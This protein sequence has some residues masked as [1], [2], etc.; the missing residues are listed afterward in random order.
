M[1]FCVLEAL[2]NA[3]KYPRA[4]EVVMRLRDDEG[5]VQLP[6]LRHPCGCRRSGSCARPQPAADRGLDA[7]VG[8]STAQL[9][10]GIGQLTASLR[11]RGARLA[12]RRG[13]TTAA[14]SLVRPSGRVLFADGFWERLPTKYATKMFGDAV[15]T[16][17]EHVE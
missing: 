9:A 12:R 10:S 2:Q 8:F 17:S 1:Y 5:T 14:T 11:R 7:R 3:Q 16:L 4:G 15:L 13:H 6:D